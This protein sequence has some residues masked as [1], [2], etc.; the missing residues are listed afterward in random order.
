MSLKFFVKSL[1]Q[2]FITDLLKHKTEKKTTCRTTSANPHQLCANYLK[3]FAL[4]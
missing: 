3:S 4:L 1:L 2:C